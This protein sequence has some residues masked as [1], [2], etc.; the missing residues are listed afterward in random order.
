MPSYKRD[1]EVKLENTFYFKL[2][3]ELLFA[4]GYRIHFSPQLL[5]PHSMYSNL[6]S[7]CRK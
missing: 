6:C 4:D 2:A 7:G 3:C 5:R 1:L